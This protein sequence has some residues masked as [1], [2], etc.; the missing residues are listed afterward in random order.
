MTEYVVPDFSDADS[1]LEAAKKLYG[2]FCDELKDNPE[3]ARL[4]L[5]SGMQSWF[6]QAYAQGTNSNEPKD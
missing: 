6:G 4:R 5:I 3:K 1:R 2:Q